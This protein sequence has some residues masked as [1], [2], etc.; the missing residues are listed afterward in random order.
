MSRAFELRRQS[1][2]LVY[3]FE[4][5]GQFGGRPRWRRTDGAVFV[6]WRDGLGWVIWDDALEAVTGRPWT[7]PPSEQGDRPPEGM[8]VSAKGAKAYVY[9]LVYVDG[10]G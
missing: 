6:T 4:P 1:D 7:L 9:A 8:W 10:A 2:E 3:R 5:D